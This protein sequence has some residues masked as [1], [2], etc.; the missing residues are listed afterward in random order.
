MKCHV[1]S[2]FSPRLFLLYVIHSSVKVHDSLDGL[3]PLVKS[4][5]EQ[6]C[7]SLC[8]D[9]HLLLLMFLYAIKYLK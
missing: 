7:V 4:G 1:V 9:C 8:Y 3:N 2:L 5:G 6:L